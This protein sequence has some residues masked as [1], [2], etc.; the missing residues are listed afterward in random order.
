MNEMRIW[1][2]EWVKKGLLEVQEYVRLC[3]AAGKGMVSRIP[4]GVSGEAHRRL[5]TSKAWCR[6]VFQEQWKGR[7]EAAWK[8]PTR[9]RSGNEVP[10]T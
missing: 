1:F 10:V 8:T 9:R 2:I 7:L 4:D 6:Q 5:R 3:I